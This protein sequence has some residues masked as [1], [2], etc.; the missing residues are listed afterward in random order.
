M[1]RQAA[2]PVATASGPARSS[3]GT[4]LRSAASNQWSA[5]V[6]RPIS[7]RVVAL[8][9]ASRGSSVTASV[10]RPA[11]HARIVSM[12]ARSLATIQWS[13]ISV[14]ASAMSPAAV[15]WRMASDAVP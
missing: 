10:G 9:R 7:C 14:A 11:S 12:R 6:V 2:I 13:R 3:G 4:G 5:S 8:T 1:A 15:A